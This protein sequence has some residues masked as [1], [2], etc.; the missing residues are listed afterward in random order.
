MLK[1]FSRRTALIEKVA[2]EKGIT[3]PDRKAELGA[4]TREKKGQASELGIAAQGMER[5]PDRQ[6][7]DRSWRRFTVASVLYARPERGEANGGRSRHRAQFR[8]R[9]GG[10]GTQARH[11]SPETRPRGGHGRGR[12]TARWSSAR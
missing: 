10:A 12:D 8:A 2:E 11:R 9:G 3:D 5:A 1:R 4:E 7:T 6:G